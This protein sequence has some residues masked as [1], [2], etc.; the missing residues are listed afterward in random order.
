MVDF[1]APLMNMRSDESITQRLEM[2]ARARRQMG[3]LADELL[4]LSKGETP[5]YE[6]VET[7]LAE[8][9]RDTVAMIRN[10]P[11]VAKRNIELD[12]AVDLPPVHLAAS[13]C[14]RMLTNLIRNAAQA[15]EEGGHITVRMRPGD[16]AVVLEVRDDG[17]G[18]PNSVRDRIFQPLFSTKG[19]AG[20]GLGLSICRA[21]MTAHGG[22]LTCES[23]PGLGTSFIATFPLTRTS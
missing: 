19:E 9:V 5:H 11:L 3:D 14:S 6:L 10:T 8:T 2:L 18:M 16:K 21:V 17:V 13:R 12:L 7:S 23:A 15:T 22:T 20:V 4:V 1:V